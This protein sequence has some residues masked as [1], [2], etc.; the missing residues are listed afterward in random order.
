MTTLYW[1]DYETWGEVPS[2]DRPSQ[3]AGLR[4]DENLN[5]IGEP[6]VIYCQ[7]TLDVLPKPE[8]CLVTGIAPQVALENGLP[9]P[10]FIGAIHREL[11]LPGTCGV[12]YNTLRFDD[13]VTRYS[14]YRNFFDPYE[15]EWRN[16]NSRWDIIDT[17]RMTYALRP[18]GIEWP[19]REDGHPSFKLE[20]LTAA[21]GI[22]HEGA[23]DALSDVIATIDLA[24]LIK[25]R[26][27]KLF[28]YLYDLRRK[29]E[30]AKLID[31]SSQ[32]PLLHVS[33][34]FS[35]EHGCAALV[36]PLAMHP[37]N[38]NAVIVC[39]LSAA[40]QALIELSAEELLQRLYLK[41][42]E[43]PE[44]QE[45]LPLKLVHLNKSPA[46]ATAKLLDDKAAS[47]LRIDVE[48]CKYHWHQLREHQV[49]LK[50]KL[51]SVYRESTFAAASDPEQQLYEGFIGDGDRQ[52]C[53]RVRRSSAADL[54][55]L[56][57]KF[58]DPRLNALLTRYRGRYHPDTLSAAER[59]DWFDWVAHRLTDP[60][61]GAGVVIEELHQRIAAIKQQRDLTPAQLKLL[62]DVE[63][64]GE[65]QVRQ[66]THL[67]DQI[68]S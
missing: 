37:V 2:V 3:F 55:S 5:P 16:G 40:P 6:L 18:E 34:R 56:E 39:N 68:A 43:L 58:Q 15:R 41:S 48:R 23:H 46:L 42:E 57:G 12:G 54:A 45:R 44:G 25:T 29:Q 21:N 20:H 14:L 60:K 36:M 63:Q 62:A 26:Q 27:P 1:H 31:L 49:S 61:M 51:E 13:E 17:V 67:R 24:R 4:T 53:E 33:S 9:E 64:F 52:L 10:E 7:P 8:A 65:Q 30:A 66:A 35:A 50:K 32:K 28:Q 38:K 19:L 47:R 59:R 22:S 11:A